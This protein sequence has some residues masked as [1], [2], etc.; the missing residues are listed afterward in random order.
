MKLVR[1][2]GCEAPTMSEQEI[3]GQTVLACVNCLKFW[4]SP[5]AEPED[6]PA[7]AQL[8]VSPLFSPN[9]YGLN[10]SNR[11]GVPD[12]EIE[13]TAYLRSLALGRDGV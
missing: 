9:D 4:T 12:A 13:R 7:H 11:H 8:V 3:D 2:Y 5:D 10:S 6:V 1:C